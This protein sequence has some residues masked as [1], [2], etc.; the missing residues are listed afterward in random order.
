MH[1][2]S[3]AA[4]RDEH[5]LR[6][7]A[8]P[9][10]SKYYATVARLLRFNNQ[11]RGFLTILCLWHIPVAGNAHGGSAL[12]CASA[13]AATMIIAAWSRSLDIRRCFYERQGAGKG[14]QNEG[15]TSKAV[16]NTRGTKP[17]TS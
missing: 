10:H 9:V 4:T 3:T 5:G 13:R 1:V 16:G 6:K 15:L 2:T 8:T 17:K 14:K 11:V 7:T 12:E